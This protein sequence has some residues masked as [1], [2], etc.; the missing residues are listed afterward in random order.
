[1]I[2]PKTTYR[3]SDELLS[4]SSSILKLL[5]MFSPE[6]HFRE[7]YLKLFGKEYARHTRIVKKL[8][9]R[10]VNIYKTVLVSMHVSVGLS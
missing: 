3:P 10:N 9:E 1:M 5:E 2:N 8:K 7:F 4:H 6:N